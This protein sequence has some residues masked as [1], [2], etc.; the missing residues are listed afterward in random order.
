MLK[1]IQREEWVLEIEKSRKLQFNEQSQVVDIL[2]SIYGFKP[3]YLLFERKNKLVISFIA[4]TK[5]QKI[6]QPVHFFYSAFWIDV[7]WSDRAYSEYLNDFLLELKKRYTRIEISLPPLVKDIRPFIWNFFSIQNWFTYIKDTADYHYDR[8]VVKNLN[9]V[10][11]LPYVFKE[12]K[13]NVL[14][15]DLNLSLFKEL[16]FT[17]SKIKLLGKLLNAMADTRYLSC[18]N[19]YLSDQLMVSHIL[20]LDFEYGIAFE[21]MKNKEDRQDKGNVHTVS[22]DQLFKYLNR[23]GYAHLDLMGG[24]MQYIAAFKSRFRPQLTP[25]FVVTYSKN[26]VFLKKLKLVVKKMARA[27]MAKF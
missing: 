14:S 17:P 2:C 22:Y 5:G 24:D 8:N 19:V 25:H 12:E 4:L 27:I 15:A 6:Y 23:M 11:D 7:E 9:K 18:F 21:I 1:I 10:S 3:I 20:F 16:G 13:L 26:E